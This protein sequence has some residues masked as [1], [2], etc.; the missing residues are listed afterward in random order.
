MC[1]RLPLVLL[2][3]ALCHMGLAQLLDEKCHDPTVTGDTPWIASIY[4][5]DEF[6]CHGT[7]VH[8]L[9]VLT[10]A[11][12]I[13]KRRNIFVRF[14]EYDKSCTPSYCNTVDQYGVAT[15]IRHRDSDPYK[16][17][18]DILLLRL[19]GEVEYNAH[20]RPICIIFDDVV[21]SGTIERFKAFEWS[22]PNQV[23][24]TIDD[25]YQK[26]YTDCERN[27]MEWQA[28]QI[29]AG[30]LHKDYCV[31]IPGGP[32]TADLIYG[33]K[34]LDVLFGI[35][36]DG[37]QLCS[38]A[39]V[40]T[41]VTAYQD[42][43]YK[44]VRDAETKAVQ[45]FNEECRTNWTEEVLVRLW[46]VSLMQNSFTGA[47]V[48]SQFVVTVASAFRNNPTVIKVKTKLGQSLDV[49]S[50]HQHPHFAYSSVPVRNNIA[51]LKLTEKLSSLDAVKPI[52]IIMNPKPS[53]T[54]T[55]L[56]NVN[57]NGFKGVYEEMIV[58]MDNSL[59]SQKIG[60][61]V[62]SNQFCVEKLGDLN[63]KPGSIVGTFQ[64]IRGVDRYVVIG[65]V[66]F[67]KNGVFVFTNVQN[68]AYWIM[69]TIND[70]VI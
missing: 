15:A 63:Q 64:N 61:I 69:D 44:N 11:S 39:S 68:H 51:L 67:Y 65:I 22:G 58:P 19:F 41:D 66:S 46:E 31:G 1:V 3:M 6:I 25:L 50:I 53:R 48:T 7:L 38:L 21:S 16:D 49:E 28:N 27:G 29:C 13:G 35:V 2:G 55:A 20:I 8:K 60:M 57:Q 56:W 9:F 14:G 54:L 12:C 30:K 23:L 32:L 37:R 34:R 10:A 70:L 36:R 18:S 52:C 45:V 40:Y 26:V 17:T 42:W 43:I 59:C 62:G 24:Q 47:L 33:G 5:N 4:N